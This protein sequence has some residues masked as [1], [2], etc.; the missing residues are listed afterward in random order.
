M[1]RHDPLRRLGSGA[2]LALIWGL[3]AGC[4]SEGGN[5]PGPNP[6]EQPPPEDEGV[7][8]SAGCSDGVLEHGALYRVCFPASWNGDLVLYAHGYVAAHRPIALPDDTVGGVSVSSSLTALGYAFATTSYRGN[9][10]I[11]VEAVE[12]LVE[13]DAT[14]RRLYQPDPGHSVIL[15]F[16]EG[17]LVGTLAVERHPDVFDGALAGCGPIGDFGAQLNYI[18]DFRVV[19][20]YLFPGVLPGTAVDI[21]ESLRSRW[22]QIY[23]PAIVIALAADFDAALEL[24]RITGAPVAGNDLRSVAET[25]VGILWYDIFGMG[26]AHARLGGQPFDNSTRVYSGSSNDAA[27]NAG[28]GRFTADPAAL[29]GLLRLQTSGNLT[30]PLVTL[31][32]TGDPIVPVQQAELYGEKVSQAGRAAQLSH[33]TIERHGHCTFQ[34]GEVLGGFSALMAKVRGTASSL[35]AL[36]RP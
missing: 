4:S 30:V 17:G 15:G 6:P 26:D 9:G 3:F 14:V 35:A 25:T 31:H 32:T 22:D 12:D 36:A 28:V 21:P 23:V 24:I 19:F 34:P 18:G 29:S 27:L 33:T 11:A 2:V 13:L 5:L 7:A 16:S 1:I 10:L 8:P 20:D